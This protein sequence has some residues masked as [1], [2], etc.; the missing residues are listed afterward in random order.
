L[1]QLVQRAGMDARR[2]AVIH[3]LFAAL[4]GLVALAFAQAPQPLLP[5]GPLLLLAVQAGWAVYVVRR[6]RGSAI[7][8]W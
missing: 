6:A 4:G 1:Y 8:T 2:V 3:W 7:G 5:L